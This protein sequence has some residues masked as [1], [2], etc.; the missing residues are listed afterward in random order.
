MDMNL[1]EFEK[2]TSDGTIFTVDFIKRTT[3]EMRKMNCRRGVKKGVTGEGRKFDPKAKN[4]LGVFDM[5]VVETSGEKGAFRFINLEGL[6]TLKFKGEKYDWDNETG[7]F[8]MT[9]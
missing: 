4:L 9:K 1:E 3:G 5:Q 6:M 8:V 2:A 7:C